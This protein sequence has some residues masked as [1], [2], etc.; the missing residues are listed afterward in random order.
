ML[1]GQREY[2]AG[3]F[4]VVRAT[5]SSFCGPDFINKWLLCQVGDSCTHGS[6]ADLSKIVL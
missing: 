6:G 5:H 3:R 4:F 1:A 2:I